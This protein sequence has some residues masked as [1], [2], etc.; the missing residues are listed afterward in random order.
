M[1]TKNSPFSAN[2]F[3]IIWIKHFISNKSVNTFK[4]ID[5]VNFYKSR[6]SLFVNVGKN[7]TKG[8]TYKINNYNDYKNNTFIIY[9]FLPHLRKEPNNLPENIGVLK[10][11]QY[12]GYLIHLDKFKNIDDYLLNT[13]SKN[14]RMK[15]RKFTKRLDECFEISTKM[16]FGNIDKTEYD[17]IFENF[18]TL[19]QKRYSEKAIS[20]N[21]MHPSEWN[22]YKEVAYPLILLIITTQKIH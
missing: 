10:S 1:K 21:N 9:D 15:M 18:M 5:G 4:F 22:F 16:F 13:F 7:L 19:L 12:P 3:Q 17:R 20:Y 14:T 6:F 2:I 11:I 8:N